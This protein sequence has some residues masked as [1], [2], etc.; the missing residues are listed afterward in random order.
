MGKLTRKAKLKKVRGNRKSNYNSFQKTLA[1]KILK[2]TGKHF[3]GMFRC[4]LCNVNHTNGYVY[5]ID[6]VEYEICKFCNDRIFH[7]SNYIRI[8]YTPMGNNQ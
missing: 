3:T 1:S 4:D 8:I 5:T 6:N 2:S 7:K